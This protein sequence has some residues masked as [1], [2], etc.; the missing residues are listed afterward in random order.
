MHNVLLMFR[1]AEGKEATA[2][3]SVMLPSVN[4]RDIDFYMNV[5]IPEYSSCIARFQAIERTRRQQYDVSISSIY[6]VF[7]SSFEFTL[8]L[9]GNKQI[10]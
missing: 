8:N 2:V 5:A 9:F 1:Y 10:V 7:F 6:F 3:I 4:T